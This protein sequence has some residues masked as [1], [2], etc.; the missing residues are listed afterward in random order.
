MFPRYRVTG[1]LVILAFLVGLLEACSPTLQVSEIYVAPSTTIVAGE[2]SS[3]TINASG[4]DLRF[5][6]EA[7]RGSLSSVTAPSVL[8]TAPALPGPDTVTVEVTGRGG[9]TVRS[10]TFEVVAEVATVPSP[11]PTPTPTPTPIPTPTPTATS[12]PTPTATPRTV[13]ISDFET[14]IGGWWF[15]EPDGAREVAKGIDLSSDASQ[16]CCSLRCEFDFTRPHAEWPHASYQVGFDESVRDW[17]SF[18]R[19]AFDAKSLVDSSFPVSVTIA[20]ATGSESC[21]HELADFLPVGQQWGTLTFELDQPRWKA[22][23]SFDRLEEL[24]DKDNVRRLHILVVADG[25]EPAG[26]ILIDNVKLLGQ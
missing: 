8:Y 16:G 22:C 12:T 3:L 25:G 9:T 11:T 17:T 19:L 26:S 18:D 7:S 21:W 10:I 5:K 14:G 24:G 20:L 1:V 4:A 15:S 13:V 23:P 2:T 6:W